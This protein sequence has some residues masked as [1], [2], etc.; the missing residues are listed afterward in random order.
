MIVP[1]ANGSPQFPGVNPETIQAWTVISY[2]PPPAGT[3]QFNLVWLEADVATI[4]ALTARADCLFI[5]NLLDDGTFDK[6][7]LEA[8]DRNATRTKINAMGFTG[9]Q[10]GQLNA[11]INSSANRDELAVKLATRAF[12]QNVKK[13]FM[14]EWQIR[15]EH[16]RSRPEVNP[17]P[18][19]EKD[20]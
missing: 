14:E 16:G 17:S 5:C 2:T 11:A 1:F 8:A 12:F 15:G 4:T 7:A 10:Y 9:A 3:A 6:P 19:V 18:V 20:A 13:D